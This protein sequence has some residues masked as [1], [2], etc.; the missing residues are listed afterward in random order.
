MDSKLG[1]NIIIKPHESA[2]YILQL[3]KDKL[4]SDSMKKLKCLLF[5]VVKEGIVTKN[6]TIEIYF[7]G[8]ESL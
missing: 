6:L 4:N 8:D 2:L 7:E 3:T 5:H 1:E